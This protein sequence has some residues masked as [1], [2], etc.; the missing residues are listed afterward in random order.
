MEQRTSATSPP[1]RVL[2]CA[3]LPAT[4]PTAHIPRCHG[5]LRSG[6]QWAGSRRRCAPSSRAVTSNA[7]VYNCSNASNTIS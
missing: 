5:S 7:K 6:L 3:T 4:A 1:P 2:P